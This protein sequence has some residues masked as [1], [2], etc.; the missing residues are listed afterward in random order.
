M[1]QITCPNCQTPIDI[2][3]ALAHQIEHNL[4]GKFQ[5]E[6]AVL[7]KSQKDLV[8]KLET[9]QKQNE[10]EKKKLLAAQEQKLKVELWQKA[11]EEARK[12]IQETS[13]K[14]VKELE[15]QLRE[16]RLRAKAAEEAELEMRKRQR[17][18][19]ERE[20]QLE[21]QVERELDKRV[22]EE[23]EKFSKIETERFS[24]KEKEYQKQIDD[25]KNL[26]EEARRKASTVSQQLQGEVMELQLEKMLRDTF[27]DDEVNE[28]KKGQ[29]G[30][31]LLQ[32][33]KNGF[34]K[35]VGIIVWESK[36]TEHFSDKWLPKLR[37]D[38]RACNGSLAVLVTRTLPEEIK[39]C[40]EVE[41]VWITSI[42]FVIPL[43]QLLRQTLLKVD[44]EKTAQSGKDIKTEM[45]YQYINSQ[46]FRGRV[47]GIV[48]SF[49]EMKDDLDR[50]QRALQN[51]W[52][53][54]EKQILRL[55]TNTAYMYGEM[56]GL[57]GA[58]LPSIQGLELEGKFQISSGTRAKT[59]TE[60]TIED[61]DE[62]F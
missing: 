60:T 42:E 8:E 7:E 46:E 43:A 3:Q 52:K 22:K 62:L 26:V 55:A 29:F 1:N 56:Q 50:E 28:V 54:R 39:T 6:K 40:G 25:M 30:A 35:S 23:Q 31:D 44:Q 59:K 36:Q 11:Q 18:I 24:L 20:K 41:R 33:V 15:E 34:G 10:E 48:E 14:A 38:C 27:S 61:Q 58:S 9:V 49:R 13:E 53:K 17:Q 51:I 4:T 32:T 2:D 37:E 12:K 45:L 47:E 19:E 57:V 16:Q 21:L 5:K